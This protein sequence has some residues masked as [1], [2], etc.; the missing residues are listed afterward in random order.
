M[1]EL[2]RTQ[3]IVDWQCEE[4]LAMEAL[5]RCVSGAE[6]QKIHTYCTQFR[7]AVMAN[8]VTLR[9]LRA[10]CNE[11]L[12]RYCRIARLAGSNAAQGPLLAQLYL[13]SMSYTDS[14]AEILALLENAT[15]LF[16]GM[17]RMAPVA[18]ATP[19]FNRESC[20]TYIALHLQEPLALSQLAGY[21]GYHEC[22]LSKRFKECF[23]LTFRQYLL[24]ARLESAAEDLRN[25]TQSVLDVSVAYC[26]CN[27]SHF[28]NAFREKFGVTPRQYRIGLL[29]QSG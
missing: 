16:N 26:F 27:Q 11:L 2:Q 3:P 9:H 23:G 8:T 7:T 21:F 15:L 24:D 1:R 29:R 17:A 13:Q 19:V 4:G 5:C 28:Q 12:Q 20:R 25:T 18:S 14:K 6:E 22:Y 10:C